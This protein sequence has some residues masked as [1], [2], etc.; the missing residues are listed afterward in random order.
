MNKL[1]ESILNDSKK[2]DTSNA[3]NDATN[4][5]ISATTSTTGSIIGSSDV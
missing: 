5:T 2:K 3:S 1:K 4:A